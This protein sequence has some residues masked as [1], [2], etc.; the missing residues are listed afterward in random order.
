MLGSTPT[1]L[2]HPSITAANPPYADPE[3]SVVPLD[4]SFESLLLSQ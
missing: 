1:S 3:A 2:G 4:N